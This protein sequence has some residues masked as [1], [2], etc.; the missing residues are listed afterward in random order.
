MNTAL[1]RVDT[2]GHRGPLKFMVD[3]SSKPGDLACF[4]HTNP[5]VSFDNKLWTYRVK[6]GVPMRFTPFK[7]FDETQLQ[8]K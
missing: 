4:A 1:I 6:Q 2:K 8:G 3:M 5:K 7:A